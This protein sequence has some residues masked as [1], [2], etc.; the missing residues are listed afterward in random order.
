MF[1][2][3]AFCSYWRRAYEMQSLVTVMR[4]YYFHLVWSDRYQLAS[5]WDFTDSDLIMVLAYLHSFDSRFIPC[6]GVGTA[7]AL[8][9][10]TRAGMQSVKTSRF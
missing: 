5:G 4:V 2:G 8:C 7:S 6:C 1:A 9:V 10:D 3:M